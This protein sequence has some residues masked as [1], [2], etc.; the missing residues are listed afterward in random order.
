MISNRA[1]LAIACAVVIAG[2]AV[3]YCFDN[4]DYGATVSLNGT[5]VDYSITGFMPCEYTY[6][7]YSGTSVPDRI[8]LYYDENYADCY[9]KNVLKRALNDL[10]KMMRDRGYNSFEYV[11]AKGLKALIDD[12]SKAV[13]SELVFING[14]IPDTIYD[15][16]TMRLVEWMD[17]GGTVLWSGPEIGLFRSHIEGC[18]TAE[19]GRIFKGHINDGKEQDIESISDLGYATGFSLYNSIPSGI[20]KNYSGSVCLSTC[21]KDYSSASVMEYSNGRIYIIGG[22]M[23][24]NVLTV[25]SALTEIMICGINED[26]VLESTNTFHKGYGNVTGTFDLQV[27]TGDLL[28]LTIGKPYSSWART[29]TF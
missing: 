18:V 1:I 19:N 15:D 3:I 9:D 17:N 21:S 13:G 25:L 14:T 22:D 12:P 5:K 26:T 11:D 8:Y 20:E 29:F 24:N 2:C 10:D 28:L 27:N 6:K 23:S 16:T 7:L 4:N